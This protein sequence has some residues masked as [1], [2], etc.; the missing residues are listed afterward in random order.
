M[1][2][3]GK[4]FARRLTV[5]SIEMDVKEVECDHGVLF[6]EE[7]YKKTPNMTAEEIRKRWP[8]GYG[9]CPKGCGFNGIYY[10]SYIHFIA[11]D[12]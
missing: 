11:G 3:L 4:S 6:D 9:L 2:G 7:E 10:A 5:W 8:R 1:I 12:W